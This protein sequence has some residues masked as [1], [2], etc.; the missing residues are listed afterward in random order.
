MKEREEK[1]VKK[2][3]NLQGLALRDGLAVEQVPNLNQIWFADGPCIQSMPTNC[4]HHGYT[5]EFPL[6]F[7]GNYV[8]RPEVSG[9]FWHPVPHQ[10]F[11]TVLSP[12]LAAASQQ[13]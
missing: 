1:K 3:Q 6:Y 11:P 5:I 8:R 10:A 9:C 7:E 13:C 12:S 4:Q 2:K